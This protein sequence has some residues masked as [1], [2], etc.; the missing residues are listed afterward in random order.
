[1]GTQTIRRRSHHLSVVRRWR[2]AASTSI[3]SAICRPAG[4]RRWRRRSLAATGGAGDRRAEL[5]A[6]R[7]RRM[8]GGVLD[9]DCAR[10]PPV[11]REGDRHRQRP[12]P[13]AGAVSAS[14][15]AQPGRGRGGGCLRP[16][17]SISAMSGRRHAPARVVQSNR[18][19]LIVRTTWRSGWRRSRAS[20]RSN[21][22]PWVARSRPGTARTSADASHSVAVRPLELICSSATAPTASSSVSPTNPSLCIRTGSCAVRAAERALVDLCYC[23]TR[24]GF[25]P[26]IANSGSLNARAH[27]RRGLPP[28][29]PRSGF[30]LRQGS[31]AH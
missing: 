23:A 26:M 10:S 31:R 19:R 9:L 22:E 18:L 1:L 7:F 8:G 20:R 27:D 16:K 13:R 14:A 17:S 25:P 5:A 12:T 24:S 11:L 28:T 6:P 15:A 2:R 29:S 21:I 30:A 3:V 4:S